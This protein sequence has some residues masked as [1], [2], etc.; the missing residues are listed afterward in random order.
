MQRIG[1]FDAKTHL[2]AL[3]KDVKT[4]EEICLT[5]RDK[6]VAFIISVEEYRDFKNYQSLKQ[7]FELKKRAPLG[8]IKDLKNEGQK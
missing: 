7:L 6:E 4:G 5:S 2:T 1:M 3:I 8:D